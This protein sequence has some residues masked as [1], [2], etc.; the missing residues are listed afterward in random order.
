M[1]TENIVQDYVTAEGI[2]YSS[3]SRL[4]DGPKAYL[5]KDEITGEFLDS[6]SAVDVLLTEGE[7]AFHSQFYVM[8]ASKPTSE[9][10]LAYTEEMI[11]TDDR[12]KAM[13]ASG[14]KRAVTDEK[15]EAEGKPYYDAVKASN[16]RV[17]LDFE[18]YQNIQATV[19]QLKENEFTA[20]Y[21]A[22]PPSNID[23]LYQVEH[24]FD[25]FYG[26]NNQYRGI[27][28]KLDIVVV[29]HDNQIIFPKDLKTTSKN[30]GYFPASYRKYRYYLQGCLYKL[31]I[32]N[33]ADKNYPGY[34]VA[35]FEFIVAQIGAF[36]EPLIFS[37]T[38]EDHNAAFFGA[39]MPSGY[40]VKGIQDL[41]LDLDYYESNNKWDYAREV[42]ENN[43]RIYLD[44]FNK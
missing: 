31:A 11:A 17:V 41:L 16:G 19:N 44:T 32:N 27:K 18:Q 34:K 5:D 3:L 15:W 7:D 6:G 9:M 24:Y 33:W 10:M 40:Y 43:G 25:M 1:T 20:R 42:R 39:N 35:D 37:M 2:S 14:Y 36:S 38:T 13:E 12:D 29:D 8:T 26:P 21:F 23:I 30:A 4:V 28:A 22:E